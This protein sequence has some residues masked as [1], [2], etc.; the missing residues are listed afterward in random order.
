M[1]LASLV[2]RGTADAIDALAQ[3]GVDH[4]LA[5]VRVI[6]ADAVPAGSFVAGPSEYN[7]RTLALGMADR[8]RAAKQA[9]VAE[10]VRILDTEAFSAYN[11]GRLAVELGLLAAGPGATWALPSETRD[12]QDY[13]V[14]I[15]VRWDALLDRRTCKACAELDDKIRPVGG[16]FDGGPMPPGHARCRCCGQFWPIAVPKDK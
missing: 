1:R 8:I 13:I 16:T 4:A 7:L 11:R 12:A 14:G 6:S 2:Q 3:L 15:V 10:G 9:N 5:E